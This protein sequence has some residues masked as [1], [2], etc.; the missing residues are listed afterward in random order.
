[1]PPSPKPEV[2]PLEQE[3]LHLRARVATTWFADENLD[4]LAHILDD[5]Y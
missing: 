4:L 1:M 3:S 2:L 5:W